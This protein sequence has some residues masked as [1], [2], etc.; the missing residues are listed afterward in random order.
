MRSLATAILQSLVVAELRYEAGAAK[1]PP[2]IALLGE[3][4]HQSIEP[5]LLLLDW[6]AKHVRAAANL[7][8]KRLKHIHELLGARMRRL[9][10][11]PMGVTLVETVRRA[12]LHK[13]RLV[14]TLSSPQYGSV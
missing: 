7:Q 14:E 2:S 8:P 4:S 12:L 5:A 10:D 6:L 1:L 11:K 13:K 3:V 9:L